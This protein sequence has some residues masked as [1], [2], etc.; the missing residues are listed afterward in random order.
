VNAY[1]ERGGATRGVRAGEVYVDV[2][3]VHGYREAV[4]LLG[5]PRS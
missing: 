3:T 1:L 2:G 5:G 4:R